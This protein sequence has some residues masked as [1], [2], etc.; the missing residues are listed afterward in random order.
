MELSMSLDYLVRQFE[1]DDPRA[2]DKAVALCKNAGFRYVDYS[3]DYISDNWEARA[4]R[5]REALDRAGLRVEQTHAPFNRYGWYDAAQFPVCYRRLFE[6]SKILGA[7]YV[8]VHGD[9]YRTVDHY[10][11]REIEDFTYDFLAPYVE[12]AEK[13]G[14]VTAIENLFEDQVARSPQIDGKSRFTARIDELQGLIERF[15]TPSVGCCWDFGH[16]NCAFGREK[17]LDAMRQVVRHIRCTHVHDNYYGKDLHL[18]PFLGEIDWPAHMACLRENGYQG[19]LSFEFVYGH[20]PESLL[21]VC[22]TTLRAVGD[23]LVRCFQGDEQ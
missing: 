7:R 9:E 3:P 8:V 1:M 16:A 2:F 10:D 19:K 21:P 4:H 5:D 15:N 14:M 18:M 20:F 23:Y 12:Y 22:L 6:G 11:R 13:A 17:A